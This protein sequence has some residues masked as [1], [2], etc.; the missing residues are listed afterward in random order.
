MIPVGGGAASVS[1]DAVGALVTTFG[2]DLTTGFGVVTT[3]PGSCVWARTSVAA[4]T[5]VIA[6]AA[7]RVFFTKPGEMVVKAAPVYVI[8]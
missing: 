4:R 5:A 8:L 6:K 7:T 2:E 1:T 3:I